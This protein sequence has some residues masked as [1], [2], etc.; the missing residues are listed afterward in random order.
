MKIGQV[1]K[2]QQPDVHKKLNKKPRKKR[3]RGKES[4]SFSDF[5]NM[6]KHDSY[7]RGKGGAIRQR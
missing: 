4:L 2:A 3:R 1:V 6:M 7:Y 5:E